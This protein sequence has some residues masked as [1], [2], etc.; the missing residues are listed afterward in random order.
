[1]FIYTSIYSKM[2]YLIKVLYE[3]RLEYPTV[4][5]QVTEADKKGTWCLG[6]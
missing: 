6:V 5:L 2:M 1:M 3:G 4:A